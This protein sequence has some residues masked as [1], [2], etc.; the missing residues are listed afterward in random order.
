MTCR[1]K[2]QFCYICGLKWPTCACTDGQLNDVL[3]QAEARRVD[4]NVRAARQRR[5]E[6]EERAAI[7][8]VEEFMR[9][10]EER[11]ARELAEIQRREEVKRRR[12]EDVRRQRERARIAA[13]EKRFRGLR[14]ELEALR[15]VQRSLMAE[16]YEFE[17][18]ALKKERQ[19]T[20]DALTIQH[21]TEIQHLANQSVSRIAAIE[22]K[23]LTEYT[24]RV[25]EEQRIEDQYVDELRTFWKGKPDGEYK[26]REA[27]DELRME[28][29]KEYG[30]WV[31]YRRRE[32]EAVREGEGRK[33]QALR[34]KQ[35][36]DV[37]AV[38]GRARVDVLEWKR[39][40]WAEERWVVEVTRERI[41]MLL[42]RQGPESAPAS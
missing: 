10:D 29:N 30:F 9:A 22:A 32:I 4:Q 8:A 14:R 31:A 33:M 34:V 18:F 39:K 25:A 19:D 3:Q 5:E 12:Q 41:L 35:S 11:M 26:V 13:V 2:A 20:L 15:D 7:R 38:D 40:K 21:P 36:A 6:E 42:E 16:R 1:C 37:K 28:Q 23:L 24:E 17:T 27:R